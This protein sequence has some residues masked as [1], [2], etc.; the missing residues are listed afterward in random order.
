MQV[1]RLISLVVKAEKFPGIRK[2]ST[3]HDQYNFRVMMENLGVSL[4]M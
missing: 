4:L 1:Y 3:G 2:F